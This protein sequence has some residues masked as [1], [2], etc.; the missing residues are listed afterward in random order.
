M[1]WLTDRTGSY[2]AGLL[3]MSGFLLMAAILAALLRRV[4]RR[5]QDAATV[6]DL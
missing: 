5:N 6:S 3:A 4:V 1:G 2:S